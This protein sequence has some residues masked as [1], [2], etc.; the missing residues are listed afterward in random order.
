MYRV[1]LIEKIMKYN[2]IKCNFMAYQNKKPPFISCFPWKNSPRFIIKELW[3]F[4]RVTQIC[5]NFGDDSHEYWKFC[6]FAI[7][8]LS[9]INCIIGKRLMTPPKSMLWC[10]LWMWVAHSLCVHHFGCT[11]HPLGLCKLISHRI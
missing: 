10:V 7:A 8:P 1:Q 5:P 4:W 9:F 3:P 2:L 6:H 11:N